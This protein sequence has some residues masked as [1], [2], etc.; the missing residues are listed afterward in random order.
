MEPF[1]YNYPDIITDASNFNL[2]IYK[3]YEFNSVKDDTTKPGLLRHQKIVSRFMNGNTDYESLLL[4]HGLG[5]GKCVHPDSIICISKDELNIIESITIHDLWEKY[6]KLG[7]IVNDLENSYW[8]TIGDNLFI[9]SINIDANQLCTG[10]INKMYKQYIKDEPINTIVYKNI[11]TKEFTTLICTLRHQLFIDGKNFTRLYDVGDLLIGKNGVKYKIYEI[12][13][14]I[15]S[16]WVYDLEIDVHHNYLVNNIYTHNT[17]SSIAISEK[18]HE[19]KAIRKTLVLTRGGALEKQY[20]E[21][22]VNI[23]TIPAN[24]YKDP[25]FIN[26]NDETNARRSKKLYSK[27]YEFDSYIKFV[28]RLHKIRKQTSNITEYHTKLNDIFNGYLFIV[29]E[30]HNIRPNFDDKMDIYKELYD[31]FHIV[32]FKRVLLLSGTPIKDKVYDIAYLM[33]LLLPSDK[34]LPTGKAF[35]DKYIDPE[36]N[37][38]KPESID[39][40][41]SYFIGRISFY[42]ANF[43]SIAQINIGEHIGKLQYLHIEP[44]YMSEY[45]TSVY[46][47]ALEMDTKLGKNKTGHKGGGG[48]LFSNSRQASLCVDNQG[49]WGTQLNIDSIIDEMKKKKNNY[50]KIKI[51]EKYSTKYANILH[52]V[53]NNHGQNIFIYNTFVKGSGIH[54]LKKFLE[55]FGY[56]RSEGN[57]SK[58]GLRFAVIT[59]E[60]SNPIKTMRILKLFNSDKNVNGEYI[61]IIIGSKVAN[62]GLTLKNVRQAHIVAPFWNFT[63]IEQAIARTIRLNSHKALLDTNQLANV[64]IYMHAS[65]PN[66]N[67]EIEVDNDDDWDL[68]ELQDD[69]ESDDESDKDDI[70]SEDSD[71][72]DELGELKNETGSFNQ[73]EHTESLQVGLENIGKE[74]QEN[75]YSIDLYMYYISEQKDIQNKKV[76]RQMKEMSVDCL[77]NIDNNMIQGGEDGSREC[78][79]TTCVLKCNNQSKLSS[80]I[81]IEFD[82]Y[83]ILY[84][85]EYKTG[86][87]KCL[88]KWFLTHNKA[89]ISDLTNVCG[90]K[91]TD[92]QFKYTISDMVIN[93]T[94]IKDRFGVQHFI[95][96][97][98]ENDIRRIYT[99]NSSDNFYENNYWMQVQDNSIQHFLNKL[100]YSKD[101][102]IINK[103]IETDDDT[104]KWKYIKQLS[105]TNFDELIKTAVISKNDTPLKKWILS[106]FNSL[107]VKDEKTG[108]IYITK[109]TFNPW[110]YDAAS[111]KWSVIGITSPDDINTMNQLLKDKFGTKGHE[112]QYYAIYNDNLNTLTLR[113]IK[114]LAIM[115]K[116]KGK[117]C[118][119]FNLLELLKDVILPGKIYISG[120]TKPDK[121]IEQKVNMEFTKKEF[122]SWTPEQLQTVY[123]VLTMNK[124]EICQ[125]LKE[126]FQKN[127]K[128]QVIF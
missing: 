22:L 50:E 103:I 66:K 20:A 98:D 12:Y 104:K 61:Q 74:L 13:T 51:I 65:I 35:L 85:K 49:N 23:C 56:K 46:S 78:D 121:K 4:Y 127:D 24:K 55:E 71:I 14:H 109:N 9:N 64:A 83:D 70:L 43:K 19:L 21:Q 6:Y 62:E 30:A 57:E 1:F 17:C 63:D 10:K 117:D 40:L 91:Y 87:I 116:G 110:K 106:K 37:L 42:R 38:F 72:E 36:T 108:N 26:L 15:Y 120:K 111:Q 59:N 97:N 126:W 112:L 122:D 93:A 48:S 31:L 125:I 79:Y 82:S 118:V 58:P 16:G 25:N 28:K 52:T 34:Q 75:L 124:D 113:S 107:I 123:N 128:M 54:V 76:E 32:E 99:F 45:Q 96:Y 29:D 73:L 80:D 92:M 100:E 89:T 68:S 3:K 7:N 33:N 41:R 60:L 5:T 11:E 69:L 95:Q 86:V 44:S 39:E 18:L 105:S 119:S 27:F 47:K 77:L 67:N 101:L 102:A 8:L 94:P 90:N 81:K 2:D 114:D 53:L 115:R 88:N 84:D